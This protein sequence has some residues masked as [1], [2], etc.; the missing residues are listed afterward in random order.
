MARHK[1]IK[2]TNDFIIGIILLGL[3]IYILLTD[4]M[5]HGVIPAAL[6]GG[7]LTRPDVYVRMLGAF[8]A[9]CA[10]ILAIKSFNFERTTDTKGFRFVIS[11]EIVLTV[12][13]LAIYT[14]LLTRIGFFASTFMMVFFLACLYLRKEKIGSGKPPLTRKDIT[15]DLL[16]ILVYSVLLVLGV[17]LVFTRALFVVLP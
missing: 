2:N 12:V 8:L 6:P 3:G 15:R 10:A 1:I 5:V 4:D 17:Y 14:A 7:D 13:A 16:I 11:M 9:L